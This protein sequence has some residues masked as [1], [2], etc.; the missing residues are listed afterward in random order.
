MSGVRGGAVV[1]GRGEGTSR[2]FWGH[3]GVV[4]TL[5]GA[6]GDG[7]QRRESRGRRTAEGHVT[8]QL[9]L[10]PGRVQGRE[11]KAHACWWLR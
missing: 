6:P 11:L 10:V 3:A 9:L 2:E 8:L 1:R 4:L 7:P 5:P